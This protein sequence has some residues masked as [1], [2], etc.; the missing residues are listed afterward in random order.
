MSIPARLNSRITRLAVGRQLSN[1]AVRVRLTLLYGGIRTEVVT[2]RPPGFARTARPPPGPGSTTHPSAQTMAYWRKVAQCMRQQGVSGFP[3]P[4]TS[5]PPNFAG[6]G[7]VSDRDGAILAIPATIE[8]SPAFTHAATT[9]GLIATAKSLAT[10]DRMSGGRLTIGVGVGWNEA[11]FNALGI[12]F[13]ERGAR[14]TEFLRI[15]QACWS[16]GA[17]FGRS[18]TLTRR[19]ASLSRTPH[20]SCALR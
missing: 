13:H 10:L 14:T 17:S 19:S 4:A 6:I 3:D 9:C 5:V 2:G 18:R 7:E 8:Q 11:E 15:W 12:P 1:R 16:P 20:T